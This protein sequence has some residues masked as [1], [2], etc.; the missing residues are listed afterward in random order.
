MYVFKLVLSSHFIYAKAV[1]EY[2]SL[3]ITLI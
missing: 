2:S 1:H 3:E